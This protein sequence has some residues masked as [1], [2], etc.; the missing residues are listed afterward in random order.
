MKTLIPFLFYLL[1][2]YSTNYII[3]WPSLLDA[4]C[5]S[6]NTSVLLNSHEKIILGEGKTTP[7][8]PASL[9]SLNRWKSL[10]AIWSQ[11]AR[12]GSLSNWNCNMAM[13]DPI[14]LVPRLGQ[15]QTCSLNAYLIHHTLP[16]LAPRVPGG[17]GMVLLTPKI[18][19]ST[20][21]QAHQK[22]WKTWIEHGRGYF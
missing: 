4:Q 2:T 1:F 8:A 6:A 14:W 5:I 17:E 7:A 13:N 19:F 11:Y 10:R 15:L 20:G 3:F 16:D 9:R 18:I 21:I 22:R 12:W